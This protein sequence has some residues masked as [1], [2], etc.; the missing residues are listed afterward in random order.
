MR[1]G[2]RDR[3]HNINNYKFF[4]ARI[5]DDV[6]SDGHSK[7]DDRR[8]GSPA[9]RE[10]FALPFGIERGCFY[11]AESITYIMLPARAIVGGVGKLHLRCLLWDAHTKYRRMRFARPSP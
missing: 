4:F 9:V 8:F 1:R 3:E 7:H 5:E 2:A 10:D 11:F 6:P